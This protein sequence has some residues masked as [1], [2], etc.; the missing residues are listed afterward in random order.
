MFEPLPRSPAQEQDEMHC[1]LPTGIATASFI[2]FLLSVSSYLCGC[3]RSFSKQFGFMQ[4]KGFLLSLLQSEILCVSV[5]DLSSTLVTVEQRWSYRNILYIHLVEGATAIKIVQRKWKK[6]KNNLILCHAQLLKW[7]KQP[8]MSF[9]FIPNWFIEALLCGK[10]GTSTQNCGSRTKL[11]DSEGFIT[12]KARSTCQSFVLSKWCL[13]TKHDSWDR[14]I[15]WLTD[16][17]NGSWELDK[18][19]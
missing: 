4:A 5:H 15:Q 1:F 3:I 10:T 14:Y 2:Y 19:Q 16:K 7:Q 8:F 11:F 18:G 13:A 17:W 6:R 12:V 9:G